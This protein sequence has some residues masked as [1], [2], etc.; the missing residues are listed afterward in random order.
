MQFLQKK[1]ENTKNYKTL[2]FSCENNKKKTYYPH[3]SLKRHYFIIHYVIK[4]RIIWLFLLFSQLN[5]R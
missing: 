4:L 3:F 5:H 2:W 1:T